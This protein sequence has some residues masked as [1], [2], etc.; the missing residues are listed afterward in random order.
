MTSTPRRCC[1]PEGSWEPLE[2]SP[3]GRY[4]RVMDSG[5]RIVDASAVPDD[6]TF[7]FIV[8]EGFDE[9][10]AL[11]VRLDGEVAAWRDYCPHWTDVRLDKG[12]SAEFRDGSLMCTRHGATFEPG[13]G[14]CTHGPCEGAL[15]RGG[16]RGGP[17][18]RRLPH[19]RRL[20][21]RGRRPEER[22]RPLLGPHRLRRQ[23]V[24]ARLDPLVVEP[25]QERRHRAVADLDAVDAL[26]GPDLPRRVRE[27]RLVGTPDVVDGVAA[28]LD[29]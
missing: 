21:V 14:A 17:R 6:S 4:R 15:P 22:P 25:A 29:G 5:S 1:R 28:G 18:R 12:S 8:R 11:L 26:D 3:T 24:A 13:S 10:E 9:K 20:R 16:R 2:P 23:L 7:L 27:E 19:R